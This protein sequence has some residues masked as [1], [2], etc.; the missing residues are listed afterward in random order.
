MSNPKR[1]I[2]DYKKLTPGVLQLLVQKYPDG[3]GDR[4][5]IKFRNIKGEAVEA[6]EVTAADTIFLVKISSKLQRS[7]INFDEADATVLG[8]DNSSEP[9]FSSEEE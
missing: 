3:Y 7:I 4:D 1:V 9:G 6:V 5:I 2:I 8:M